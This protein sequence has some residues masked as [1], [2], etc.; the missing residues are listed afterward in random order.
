MTSTQQQKPQTINQSFD[1]WH[2]D[3]ARST[4]GPPEAGIKRRRG[5]GVFWK[6]SSRKVIITSALFGLGYASAFDTPVKQ[7][8][9]FCSYRNSTQHST[10]L[11]PPEESERVGDGPAG[12]EERRRV[13]K[14]NHPKINAGVYN[15]SHQPRPG[16]RPRPK[17]ETQDRYSCILPRSH[18]VYPVTIPVN[19]VLPP[20]SISPRRDSAPSS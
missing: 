15:P 9:D 10:I 17:P 6:R 5:R 3:V 16:P 13:R 19:L 18:F 20:L 4:R 14:P 2:I 12:R 8:L 7:V 1:G 11:P